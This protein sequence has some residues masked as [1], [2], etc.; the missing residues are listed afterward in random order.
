MVTV[1]VVLA[2]A[3]PSAADAHTLTLAQ[4]RSSMLDFAFAIAFSHDTAQNPFVRCTRA[5]GSAHSVYCDWGF[6]R[7]DAAPL[8][9]RSRCTGRY[10]VYL[11]G[12]NPQGGAYEVLAPAKPQRAVARRLSCRPA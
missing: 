3:L 7:Q 11:A 4:A 1:S 5:G 6:W 9:A 12:A 8:P 10:R 2:L